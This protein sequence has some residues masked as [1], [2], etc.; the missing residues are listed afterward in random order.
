MG[1]SKARLVDLVVELWD[2]NARMRGRLLKQQRVIDGLVA[3]VKKT[4]KG[5]D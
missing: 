4:E 1:L 3:R 5:G 2:R